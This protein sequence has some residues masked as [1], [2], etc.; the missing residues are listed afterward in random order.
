[1]TT[2]MQIKTTAPLDLDDYEVPFRGIVEQSIAGIYILQDGRFQYVNETFARMCGYRREQLL[3]ARLR[4]VANPSQS[5]ALMAQYERR[6]QGKAP[7]ERFI[8][9]RNSLRR[10]GSFEIHGTRVIFRGRP[11]VVGVGVDISE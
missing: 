10:P 11:A 3:G 2:I 5:V 9:R 1:M 8:V 4:D 6:I 7:R